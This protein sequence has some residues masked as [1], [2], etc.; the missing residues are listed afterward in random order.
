M[1]NVLMFLVLVLVASCSGDPDRKATAGIPQFAP[2][3]KG[4][5]FTAEVGTGR[6]AQKFV[7]QR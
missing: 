2:D 4:N 7:R 3:S 1:K 5:V 6:R